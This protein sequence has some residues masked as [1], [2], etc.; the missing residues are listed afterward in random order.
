MRVCSDHLG[1]QFHKECGVHITE[2]VNMLRIDK[3]KKYL[4]KTDDKINGI[5]S[6]LGYPNTNYFCKVFK[7]HVGITPQEFRIYH[8]KL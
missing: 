1:R 2:Y 7:K 5:A 6:T 3:S 4:I 8:N